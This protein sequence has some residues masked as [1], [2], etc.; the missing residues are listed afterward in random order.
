VRAVIQ[1][2]SSARVRVAGETVG[3]IGRGLLVLLGVARGDDER[4]ADELAARIATFR[5]FSDDAGRMNLD[6]AAAGGAVLVVSQFTLVADVRRGR[7]PSFDP[8]EEP[9]RA[10]ALVERFAGALRGVGLEVASGRFGADM[11]VELSNDG[12]V[13]FVLER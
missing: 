7:R 5:C 1:R 9:E 8:A 2:V 10:Q 11:A 12:P 4:A 6:I 13:T 3:E